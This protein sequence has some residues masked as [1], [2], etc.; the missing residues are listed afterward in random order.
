MSDKAHPM[1]NGARDPLCVGHRLIGRNIISEVLFVDATKFP[2]VGSQSCASPFTAIAMHLS[3]PI[4]VIVSG[5]LPVAVRRAPMFDGSV[6]GLEFF[7]HW[8]ISTPLIGVQDSGICGHRATDHLKACLGI[9]M[10]AHKEAHC[11]TL[12]PDNG[13]DRRAIRFIRAMPFALIGAASGRITGVW[14]RVAFFPRH[15]DRV[16]QPRKLSLRVAPQ[17]RSGTDCLAHACESHAA[18]PAQVRVRASR[19]VDSPLAIPRRIKTS[20]EGGWRVFSKTVS[21]RIE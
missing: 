16:H 2:Q 4:S 3:P 5:P 12:A 9:C 1:N 19:A 13:E 20:L 10:M 15:S 14:V 7:L 21:V 6:T 8:R 17:V 11:P 18:A